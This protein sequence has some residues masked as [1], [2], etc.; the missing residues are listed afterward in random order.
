MRINNRAG[1]DF[2]KSMPRCTEHLINYNS[3]CYVGRS[4]LIKA[5]KNSKPISDKQKSEIRRFWKPYLNTLKARLAFDMR[6]FDVYN[7]TNVF[8]ADL[9][10]YVPDGYYYAIIDKC[11]TNGIDAYTMDD[12]NLYDL[13]FHD[14]NQPATIVRKVR[15]VYLDVDYNIISED[16][17]I[18]KCVN[19]KS[20]VIKP[21]VN[22]WAGKGI[23]F[24]H[25]EDGIQSLRK[26]FSEKGS[27]VVQDRIKQHEFMAQFTDSCVNT[28]RIV[29]L[30]WNN[31]IHITSS[32]LIMGGAA[33]KTNH[34]HGGGIVC[35]IL[36][37]GH[38]REIAFDGNL[39]E[40]R[41]HPNGIVF[42]NVR[43][44]NYD[45]CV[46]LVKKLAP[47]MIGISK[48][49]NW[50]ITLDQ[51]GEPLLIEVNLTFGGSVQIA[52]GPAFGNM[53]V[54]ILNYVTRTGIWK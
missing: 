43:I 19:S 42:A 8:G 45:K 9:T 41:Q 37:N 21:S 34:L 30:L 51:N 12:K 33:A 28:M 1:I 18:E 14:I 13:Y 44:P 26:A 36:P 29:T 40:Y 38:L 25:E 35:G 15:G 11:L 53:T 22:A 48:L 16:E 4:D 32:V 17:A 31:E 39:N 46:A 7:R 10:T 47:R 54:E 52:A 5:Y 50:D 20:V 2:I 6:W 3:R 23:V 24:W 27:V 49:L